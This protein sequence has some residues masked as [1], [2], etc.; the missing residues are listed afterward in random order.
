MKK[1]IIGTRGSDLALW[2]A[3]HTRDL[4]ESINVQG[5]IKIIHTKG[6]HQ[7]GLPASF[8][9]TGD[10]GLFTRELE[11]AL[12]RK[13]IDIAV[14]SL[15][16]LPYELP[17]GLLLAGFTK[18]EEPQDVIF[19]KHPYYD[20]EAI[21][22]LKK[23]C[24]VG[25]SSLRRSNQVSFFRKDL[26]L[27]PVRGNVP[28]R[29]KK[30][31]EN[32]DLHALILAKAGIQRLNI[33]HQ[34]EDYI[35]Y[36]LP[37]QWM[38]PAPGQGIIAWEIR[39][40]DIFLKDIL[41]KISCSE[42][43]IASRTERTIMHILEAGCH[44]PLGVL[45]QKNDASYTITVSWAQNHTTAP[46]LVKLKENQPENSVHLIQKIIRSASKK[47]LV[48]KNPDE[49]P[50]IYRSL[51]E[52]HHEV[53]IKSFID[54]QEIPCPK[55]ISLP[56]ALFFNSPRAVE[57]FFRC[58]PDISEK[59]FVGCIGPGTR[60]KLL[61]K[62]I[63]PEFTGKGN[64]TKHIM[65]EFAQLAQNKKILIP[66]AEQHSSVVEEVFCNRELHTIFPVYRT[67]PVKAKVPAT[68][69]DIA[70]FTSPSQWKS[71][72]NENSEVIIKKIIAM[73]KTT[74][75]S[76]EQDGFRNIILSESFEETDLLRTIYETFLYLE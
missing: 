10:K 32:P 41:K 46:I 40:D 30:F 65:T 29:I 13:E 57:Y 27:F 35:V 71:F 34:T 75:S 9:K 64:N 59:I 67:V 73:G 24:S 8:I 50:L 43:E 1:I 54:F 22:Y 58:Y 44:A 69:Y 20:S 74:A 48:T 17:K 53:L 37:T 49:F 68:F 45:V 28:T 7:Q 15:K 61:E 52:N 56:E 63:T 66:V 42:S 12:F 39:E 47:I 6:D 55:N 5:D 51:K 14:H 21:F 36:D 60:K 2:Q 11:E 62:N 25:T 70:V 72:R 18:R 3:N 4:L 16:D 31:L 19:I 33:P 23:N 26:Q 38:V 76:I